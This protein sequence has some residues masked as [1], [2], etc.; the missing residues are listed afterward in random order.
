LAATIKAKRANEGHGVRPPAH[1][2]FFAAGEVTGVVH[3]ACRPGS[4][5]ITECLEFERIAGRN[6]AS[7]K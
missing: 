4:C 6:A 2:W 1:Q 3:G 7:T 5:T